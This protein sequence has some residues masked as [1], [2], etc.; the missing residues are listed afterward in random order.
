V[1]VSVS[2]GSSMHVKLEANLVAK[3]RSAAYEEEQHNQR[4]EIAEC[5]HDCGLV[6]RVRVVV[7]GCEVVKLGFDEIEAQRR[8]KMLEIE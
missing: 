5:A 7:V 8:P 4:N 1:E 2:L 3:V 6:C